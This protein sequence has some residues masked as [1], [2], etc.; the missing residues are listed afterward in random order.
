MILL[1]DLLR[2]TPASTVIC[3]KRTGTQLSAPSNPRELVGVD[4]KLWKSF[5]QDVIIPYRIHIQPLLDMD[6]YIGINY[7]TISVGSEAQQSYCRSFMFLVVSWRRVGMQNS[8][9]GIDTFYESDNGLL[10][11]TARQ[12]VLKMAD[13]T[14]DPEHLKLDVID[15]E[16]ECYLKLFKLQGTV[17][18]FRDCWRVCQLMAGLRQ[19]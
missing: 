5:D 9:G 7:D 6:C 18:S 1:R 15:N 3:P 13:S 4:L 11:F 14:K 12:T 10:Q 8:T 16:Q 19:Q 2:H 17:L